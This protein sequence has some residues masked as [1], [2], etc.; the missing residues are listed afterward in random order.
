MYRIYTERGSGLAVSIRKDLDSRGAL[1][2]TA[3]TDKE[4]TFTER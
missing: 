1:P 3:L 4:L 2:A